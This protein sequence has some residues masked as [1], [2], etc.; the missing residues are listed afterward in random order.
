MNTAALGFATACT[1]GLRKDDDVYERGD[2]ECLD[3]ARLR[4]GAH[5]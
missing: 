2:A 4:R 1:A 3:L 5:L